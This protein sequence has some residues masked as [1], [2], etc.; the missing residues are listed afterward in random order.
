MFGHST[1]ALANPALDSTLAGSSAL[2]SS[3]LGSPERFSSAD[4]GES[5][6][7]DYDL[8]SDNSGFDSSSDDL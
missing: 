7:D 8:T 6:A 4:L 2:D 1:Q 5:A 3:P